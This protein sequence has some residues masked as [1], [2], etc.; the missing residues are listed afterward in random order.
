MARKAREPAKDVI[1]SFRL[2][3]SASHL[4]RRAHFRA[5]NLYSAR[6]GDRGLTP[7]QK[8]LLVAAYQNPGSTLNTLADAVVLDRQT[9]AEMVHR[10]VVRGLLERSRSTDDRR[11]YSIWIS[12]A[13]TQLLLEVLPDDEAI[14]EQILDPLPPEVRPL[15]MKCLRLMVAEDPAAQQREQK[16]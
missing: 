16:R 15:F 7:R 6:L 2:T 5:E 11:A 14:E 4:L 12:A 1:G 3:D 10:L 9:V 13:G 8:A